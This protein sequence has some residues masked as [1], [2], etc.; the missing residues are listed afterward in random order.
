MRYEFRISKDG[1]NCLVL[2]SEDDL[3]Q[4]LLNV[5]FSGEVIVEKS[6]GTDEV[7]ICSKKK[8]EKP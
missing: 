8:E 1:K 6:P 3:E 2:K 7:F 5:V 4:T